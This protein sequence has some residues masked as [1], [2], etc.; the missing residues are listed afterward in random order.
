MR[1][2]SPI[3]CQQWQWKVAEGS[4]SLWRL[5]PWVFHLSQNDP[6]KKV[7]TSCW[8]RH[9]EVFLITVNKMTCLLYIYFNTPVSPTH[10]QALLLSCFREKRHKRKQM[11]L[12]APCW[13]RHFW[14][15]DNLFR[16]KEKIKKKKNVD[17]ALGSIHLFI[18]LSSMLR[19]PPCSA[20]FFLAVHHFLASS[21]IL[22]TVLHLCL[23]FFLIFFTF[24]Y[25][26][27][28]VI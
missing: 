17:R 5:T 7:E 25:L 20:S 13:L 3:M 21:C 14:E 6:L 1:A 22:S 18:S 24:L 28:C 9:G 10:I 23:L 12:T 27:C 26:S 2:E 8:G 19:Y 15:T 11:M 4:S 16:W